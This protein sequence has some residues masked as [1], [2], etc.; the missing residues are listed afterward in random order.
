MRLGLGIQRVCTGG[1]TGFRS[2]FFASFFFR[3]VRLAFA[4]DNLHLPALIRGWFT[5]RG[6]LFRS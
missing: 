1:I 5:L 6:S 3:I 4:L 2:N